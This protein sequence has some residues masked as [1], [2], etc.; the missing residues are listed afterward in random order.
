MKSSK[1]QRAYGTFGGRPNPYVFLKTC[2]LMNIYPQMIRLGD[3]AKNGTI[4]LVWGLISYN[5]IL[6]V[7]ELKSV[8]YFF[9][10]SF[11][12]SPFC[13]FSCHLLLVV[14]VLVLL[15]SLLF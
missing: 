2:Y 13:L 3:G 4:V 6:K 14:F 1:L 11:F 8:V 15:F 12:D 7:L 5:L 9:P 10:Y